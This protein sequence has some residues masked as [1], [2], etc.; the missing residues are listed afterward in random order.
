MA[1]LLLVLLVGIRL[2]RQSSDEY[3]TSEGK[4]GVAYVFSDVFQGQDTAMLGNFAVLHESIAWI[5]PSFPGSAYAAAAL[6]PIPRQMWPEKPRTLDQVLNAE[7]L[8]RQK[9]QGFGFS[10]TF[11]GEA[12]YNLGPSGVI[13]V[14]LLVGMLFARLE[15]Y[16][17][18]TLPSQTILGAALLPLVIVILRG[19]FSADA[20]R[21]VMTAVPAMLY[22]ASRERAKEIPVVRHRFQPKPRQLPGSARA[23]GSQSA[24]RVRYG[25]LLSRPGTRAHSPTQT[26]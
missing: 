5:A 22:L 10:F 7:L 1:S 9:Q 21:L 8:P 12:Y 25:L 3:L 11:L 23:H 6:S 2:Y 24:G 14:G 16:I 15:E 13:G 4:N 26:R 18:S 20:P 19:S 17:A